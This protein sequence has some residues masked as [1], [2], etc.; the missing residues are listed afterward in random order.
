[1]SKTLARLSECY[2]GP[3]INAECLVAKLI[4]DA[5]DE[6]VARARKYIP[7]VAS[8]AFCQALHHRVQHE[9]AVHKLETA[10]Y[11]LPRVERLLE[12]YQVLLRDREERPA[13]RVRKGRLLLGN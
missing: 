10:C 13:D 12:E 9:N 11:F 1:M 2:L 5:R 8:A 4:A 3:L 6:S 7:R